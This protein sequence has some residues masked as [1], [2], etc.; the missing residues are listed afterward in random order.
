MLT[1]AFVSTSLFGQDFLEGAHTFSKKKEA[2]L[3]L[4]DGTE[5]VGFIKDIDRK[6]GLIK[7]IKL[8][9][10]GKKIKYKP[11]EV[12]SMYIAPSGFD[13]F[14]SAYSKIA[15]PDIQDLTK[16]RTLNNERIKEGYVFFE[17]VEVKIKKKT[18]TL[19]M[20][21]VNPGYDQKIRVYFDPHASESMGL[22]IGGINVAG[23]H[24]KSYYVKKGN[25]IAYK[26]KKKTY[27]KQWENIFD[28]CRGIKKAFKGKM[29]WKDL[30]KQ[31]YH[32][33][34]EC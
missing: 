3:T 11:E 5:V 15:N 26:L 21:L 1:L 27:K 28:G 20:Q 33:T 29:S 12:K 22:G 30:S 14:S 7:E 25:E 13:K 10:D 8:K 2:Y 23:G 17:T 32:Y 6:K 18:R 16:D 34:T 4:A 31:I 9:V 24:A 19:L